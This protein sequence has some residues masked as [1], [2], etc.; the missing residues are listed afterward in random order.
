MDPVIG[1]VDYSAENQES[2]PPPPAAATRPTGGKRWTTS[3]NNPIN[4]KYMLKFPHEIRPDLPPRRKRE[5]NNGVSLVNGR[6]HDPI[7]NQ[8]YSHYQEIPPEYKDWIQPILEEIYDAKRAALMNRK[9][10]IILIHSYLETLLAN[11]G[12]HQRKT[13]KP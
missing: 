3:N 10:Y 8:H 2:A 12:I 1:D 13:R 7:S 11:M 4:W 5:N 6:I 9:K